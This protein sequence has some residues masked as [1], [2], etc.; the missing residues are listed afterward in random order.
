MAEKMLPIPFYTFSITA[1]N[2]FCNNFFVA[3]GKPFISLFNSTIQLISI[4]IASKVLLTL[5]PTDPAKEMFS[6][7]ACNCITLV[8]TLIFFII[9]FIP[10]YKKYKNSVNVYPL[11]STTIVP[12]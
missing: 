7:T 9:N 12:A 5:F 1:M 11:Q 6:Y 2:M 8:L 4:C 3:I 10:L